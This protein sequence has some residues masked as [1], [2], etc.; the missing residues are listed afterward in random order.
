M[1]KYICI[2]SE[3]ILGFL[4]VAGIVA[5]TNPHAVLLLLSVLNDMSMTKISIQF[6]E[7]LQ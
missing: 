4:S 5:R 2:L 7:V 6:D 1:K 3:D